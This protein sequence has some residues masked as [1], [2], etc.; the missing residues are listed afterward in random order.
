MPRV[1]VSVAVPAELM[2][3]DGVE[4]TPT[5]QPISEG[6]DDRLHAARSTAYGRVRTFHADHDELWTWAL[7]L[8]SGQQ[9]C[10][11]GSGNGAVNPRWL[12]ALVRIDDMDGLFAGEPALVRLSW[13]L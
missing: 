11:S 9:R 1:Y 13:L 2:A 8:L 6:D 12:V 3:S 4:Q 7:S 5:Q 10:G